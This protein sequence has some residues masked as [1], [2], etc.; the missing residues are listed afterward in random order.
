MNSLILVMPFLAALIGAAVHLLA[1]FY[2]ERVWLPANWP[3]L[4][5]R[6][7]RVAAAN[8]PWEK[9]EEQL[10]AEDN[11][12]KLLPTIEQH[13]DDFLRNRLSK[14]MPVISLFIGDRT[15]NQL[16]EIFMKELSGLLPATL[17][18]YIQNLRNDLDPGKILTDQLQAIPAETLRRQLA[19]FLRPLRTGLLKL[20]LLSGLAIGGLLS[21]LYWLITS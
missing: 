19:P 12:N 16:K 7:A 9:L 20:G 3:R 10:T 15:I 14:A 4:S 17:S 1:G 18:S 2:L 21:L 8:I 13:I 5:E 6:V 11:I